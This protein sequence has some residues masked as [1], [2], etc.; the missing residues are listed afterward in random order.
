MKESP[1]VKVFQDQLNKMGKELS[2]QLEAERANLTP[3]EFYKKRKERYS[4]FTKVKIE[5]ENE[6]DTMIHKALEKVVKD[7][8]LVVVLYKNM[9]AFAGVDVTL[10]VMNKMEEE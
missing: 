6:I 8:N 5:K 7:K 9:V 3:D 1:K 2:G 10:D 4:D